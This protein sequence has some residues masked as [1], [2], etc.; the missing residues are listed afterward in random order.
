MANQKIIRKFFLTNLNKILWPRDAYTKAD[1]IKY[2][3]EIAPFIMEHLRERPLVF[4]RYP[5]GIDKKFFYQK[6]AP[7][8]TPDWINTFAWESQD[9]KITRFILAEEK[10]TLVW[11]ANQACIEIHPWLSRK[12]SIYYPDYVV[13]DLDPSPGSSFEDTVRIALLLKQILDE[14]KLQAFVKTSGATGLHIYL[15]VINK[16]T[17]SELRNIAQSLAGIVCNLLP[18]KATIERTVE[19]RGHRVYID[20]LQN[21]VGKTICAP[22][23]VRPRD[24]ATVS[25]PLRWEELQDISGADF[26]I[27]NILSRL[28]R[29]GDIFKPVLSEKQDL[30]KAI[31][32]LG[33][34][35]FN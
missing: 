24:G 29:M 17:Y 32:Y 7:N 18:D 6:N 22:Y 4:T 5:D 33:V 1:L 9:G 8:H 31:K 21:V 27:K 10:P 28:H 19:K 16:Y 25:T 12:D 11:L 30:E 23:S 34:N 20:C 2:Y 15:P 26:T 14:F 3:A 13:F 35:I